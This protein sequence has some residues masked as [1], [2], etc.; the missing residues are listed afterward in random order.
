MRQL[1]TEYLE[2]EQTIIM[3]LLH[4]RELDDGLSILLASNHVG[5]FKVLQQ[6]FTTKIY[7][8]AA[9]ILMDEKL[10]NIAHTSF[11][12]VIFYTKT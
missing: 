2:E 5:Y 6:H 10:W 8:C 1:A 11:Q 3:S 9:T 4:T 12:S 7:S